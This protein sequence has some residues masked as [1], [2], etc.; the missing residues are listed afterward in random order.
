M[1]LFWT[2][3]QNLLFK[4]CHT[5][6]SLRVNVYPLQRVVILLFENQFDLIGTVSL[7]AERREKTYDL[8]PQQ[9]QPSIH[10]YKTARWKG[11]TNEGSFVPGWTQLIL[12][13]E[14]WLCELRVGSRNFPCATLILF[15]LILFINFIVL[16]H[17][18]LITFSSG[19]LLWWRR[20]KSPSSQKP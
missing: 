11:T 13:K 14:N 17:S 2:I 20:T 7:G 10:F 15:P 3:I 18:T 6:K 1:V 19:V 16:I 12:S 4:C 9:T 8:S 5:G